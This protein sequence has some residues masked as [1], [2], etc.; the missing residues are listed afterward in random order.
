[1]I[2]QRVEHAVLIGGDE[3]ERQAALRAEFEGDGQF[4]AG[5]EGVQKAEIFSNY[6]EIDLKPSVTLNDIAPQLIAKLSL[7]KI[8]RVQPSLLS[9]FID[10]VGKGNVPEGFIAPPATVA[11]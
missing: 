5:L 9:I 1:M 6:A 10:I 3:I 2:T 11:A 4:I 8:E 7:T